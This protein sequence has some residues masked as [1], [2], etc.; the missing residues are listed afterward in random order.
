MSKHLDPGI[1]AALAAAALFDV[2]TP[3]AKLLLTQTSK[4]KT[5]SC[6]IFPRHITPTAI[7]FL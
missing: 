3:F 1:T 2:G 4:T 7:N 5:L 6:P